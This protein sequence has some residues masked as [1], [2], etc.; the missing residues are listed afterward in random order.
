MSVQLYCTD[1]LQVVKKTV[2]VKETQL[3]EFQGKQCIETKVCPCSSTLTLVPHR[4]TTDSEQR[5]AGKGH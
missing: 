2:K 5:V 3:S 1:Q 4:S